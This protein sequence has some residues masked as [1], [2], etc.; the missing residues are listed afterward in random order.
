VAH[1]ESYVRRLRIA[2]RVKGAL[3]VLTFEAFPNAPDMRFAWRIPAEAPKPTLYYTRLTERE[4]EEI[5]RRALRRERERRR[6]PTKTARPARTR[7]VSQ[8]G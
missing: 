3:K 4:K 8:I 2:G 1:E 5:G 6:W 7:T